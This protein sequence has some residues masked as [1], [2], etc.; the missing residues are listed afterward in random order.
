MVRIETNLPRYRVPLRAVLIVP[1]VLQIFATVGLVGYLSFKN[2]QEAIDKLAHQLMGEIDELVNQH[3]DSYLAVP[4]QLNQINTDA[5][6]S[7]ILD[8]QN[9]ET[10]GR[11]FW[12]QMQV[13][14]NLSYIFSALPTGEYTGAGRWMEGG[15]TTI[16]EISLRTNYKNHTYLTDEQGNR[17]KVVFQAEYKPLEEY[18]YK[19]AIE[20]GK[21]IWSKI[22]NWQDTPEFISISASR[23]VY[24]DQKKLIGVM[25]SDLLLSNI[26]KFLHGLRAS[27]TGTI[28]ILERDGNIVASSSSEKPFK[29]VK[30]KAERL[31]AVQSSNALIRATAIDLQKRFGNLKSIKTKQL[32]N[33]QLERVHHYA[34]VNSWQDEYGLDWLVVVVIPESSFMSQIN[35]NTQITI[36]LCLA[37]L[38]V[39]TLIGFYTSRW[40]THPI[41]K[42]SKASEAMATGNLEQAVPV[43]QVKELG[44][45]SQAF[46]QM[47][48]QLRD[49]FTVLEQTNQ[50]LELRVEERTTEL[51]EAKLAADTANQAKSEFLANMSH[52]LRT[53]LNGI[54]GYAQILQRNEPLTPKGRNGIDI[55]YQCGAHLLTLINDVLDLSKIEARKLELYPVPFHFPSF[56]QSVVEINRVRAEQKGII[57]DYHTD[58]QLPV[59]ISADEKRLRQVLIN[60]LS[61]AIKFT[62]KGSV[63][64]KVR[65]NNEKIRFQIEDTGVGMTREQIE[66]IFLPFEQVGDTK[67]QA[68]GTGLGLAITHKIIS[69]MQSEINVESTPGIGS[70][71]W[72]EI[73]LQQVKDWATA[74][75]VVQQ[76]VI[77]GYQGQKQKILLVDDRWENRSVLFNLLEP[78]GFVL[79]EASNGQE[80][81][82]LSL[83]EFPDLIITDLAM[84]VMDGFEFLHKLRLHPKLKNT[85]VLV[86]SASVFEIDRYKSIDAGGDDF[87][88][89]P[90]QAETLLELIQKYLNLDWIY[91]TEIKQSENII[92]KEGQIEAPDITIL[93]E[94]IELAQINELDS[95]TDIAQQIHETHSAFACEL[96]RLVDA[97]EIKQLRAFIQQYL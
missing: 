68:E 21:P 74:S 50:N 36:L 75:R 53:P 10:T 59:G 79:I 7:K 31:S 25:A 88:P 61:N 33:I 69:L 30:G 49:S 77:T 62:D 82:E 96:I 5:A 56:L 44:V 70:I 47:A 43:S 34:L 3:L 11:Y 45:L 80:G 17:D 18:W 28:F 2:G 9:L 29:L 24:D 72:F 8:I 86:S 13:H 90:V 20:T 1:F 81:I 37:A 38:V 32:L 66:K 78:I 42:L 91:D 16:D 92:T 73:E 89:K 46:N 40:I 55:I 4:Q 57:F 15:K 85:I 71:F 22:Y 19:K 26:S 41:T 39:A 95:I 51:K 84:P 94:L 48:K 52:E 83:K 97:C 12:Q 58:S 93:N 76:G 63:T 27:Q 35:A 23:P 60:L 65:L 87:L 14:Q 67:K 64:F 6:S 54:L